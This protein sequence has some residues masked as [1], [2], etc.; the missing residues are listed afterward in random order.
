LPFRRVL[1]EEDFSA[2]KEL[3]LPELSS[4]GLVETIED[5]D[6]G[7]PQNSA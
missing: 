2:S 4:H 6:S 5:R 1:N 7:I 3:A